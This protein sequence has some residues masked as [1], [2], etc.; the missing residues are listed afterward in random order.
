MYSN[1]LLKALQSVYWI[2]KYIAEF[3]LKG[4]YAVYEAIKFL[5]T[6]RFT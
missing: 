2:L 1:C 4:Q 5:F 3:L 6:Y